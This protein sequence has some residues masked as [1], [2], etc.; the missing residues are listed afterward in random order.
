MGFESYTQSKPWTKPGP[1][2]TPEYLYLM[3]LG[4]NAGYGV[5]PGAAGTGNDAWVAWIKQA[6]AE[7]RE[8]Q[9]Y[10]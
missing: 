5:G 8:V 3:R 2:S 10:F 7:Y 1:Y 6:I 4:Y 9:P